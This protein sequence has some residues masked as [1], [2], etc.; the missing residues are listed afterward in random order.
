MSNYFERSYQLLG[1]DGIKKLSESKIAIFGIGGVGSFAAEALARSGVG[2]LVFIDYDVIDTTNVNR[3]LHATS[4]T[5]GLKKTEVMRTRVLEINP[6]IQVEVLNECYGEDTRE[7]LL[8]ISY[9]YV[10]DAID[11]IS[12]KVDLITS[13]ISMG[14]P[15]ISSMGAG[16]KLDPTAFR[17]KDIYDTRVCPLARVMRHELR[18]RGIEE[19]KV[20]YSEEPPISVNLGDNLRRKA[21][22][23]SVSFVPSVAGLILAGEVI[24][25]IAIRKEYL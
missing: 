22:P 18:K 10:I 13:T 19:L 8:N 7:N 9:D 4:K 11:M 14:I 1:E 20:V 23:G 16:N 25:D 17:V 5:V 6:D 12:S 21:I 15:I 24:K 2:S 3:Q